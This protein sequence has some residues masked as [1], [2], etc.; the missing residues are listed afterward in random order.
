MVRRE[1]GKKYVVQGHCVEGT[2]SRLAHKPRAGVG[3]D[4]GDASAGGRTGQPS[5]CDRI[6]VL[7]ADAFTSVEGNIDGCVNASARR[8]LIER[9]GLAEKAEKDDVDC[10][11]RGSAKRRQVTRY[12]TSCAQLAT[13]ALQARRPWR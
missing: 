11:S 13:S 8:N 12:G 2:A 9:A 5:S 4:V 6:S 1:T 7:G 10:V 3:E